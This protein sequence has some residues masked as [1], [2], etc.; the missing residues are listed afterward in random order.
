MQGSNEVGTDAGIRK[1]RTSC[2]AELQFCINRRLTGA[3]D[4]VRKMESSVE[5][6]INA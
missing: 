5:E 1:H 6:K 3:P 2:Y 4:L